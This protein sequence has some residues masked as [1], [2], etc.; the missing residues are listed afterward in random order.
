M[1]DQQTQPGKP[2]EPQRTE[3][4]AREGAGFDALLNKLVRI[5]TDEPRA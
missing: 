2:G 5:K 1:S 4:S 3:P